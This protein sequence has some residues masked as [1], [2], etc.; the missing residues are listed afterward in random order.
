[1]KNTIE[2]HKSFFS[3]FACVFLIFIGCFAFPVYNFS[4]NAPSIS[5]WSNIFVNLFAYYEIGVLQAMLYEATSWRKCSTIVLLMT[6]IGLLCRYLLEFGEVS[7][8]YN[9]ILPNVLL[10]LLVAVCV[11]GF[12]FSTIYENQ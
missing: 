9:F 11:S 8:T 7:N 4:P 10:Q 12:A 5:R 6:I 2:K 1:M 3:I